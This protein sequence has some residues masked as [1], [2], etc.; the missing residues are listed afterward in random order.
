LEQSGGPFLMGEHF[1]LSDVHMLPFMLRLV[2]SLKHFK[3][4]EIPSDKFPR[5]LAWYDLCSQRESVIAASLTH[6]KIIELYTMFVEMDYK[7]GGLNK[8]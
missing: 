3:G 5:L 6:E 1:T 2:V 8:N 4:Y 7:F